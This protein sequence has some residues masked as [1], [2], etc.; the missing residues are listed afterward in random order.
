MSNLG[1]LNETTPS[2]L[3][4]CI[5]LCGSKHNLGVLLYSISY[6]QQ[7]GRAKIRNV[8]GH[9]VA[10]ERSWWA[11]ETG[12]TVRQIDRCLP[13]LAAGGLIEKRPYWF[14]GKLCLFMRL[15]KRT[16]DYLK[17]ATTWQ[18]VSEFHDLGKIGFAHMG[19]A[20][21]T[22]SGSA[23]LP[24]ADN[25]NEVTDI[26]PAKSLISGTSNNIIHKHNSF[27]LNVINHTPAAA[28]PPCGKINSLNSTKESPGKTIHTIKSLEDAWKADDLLPESALGLR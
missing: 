20:E 8:A 7:Y 3:A 26:E 6:W 28:S 2:T 17:A 4:R 1:F 12:M 27:G 10:H 16:N 23:L 22:V 15:T 21:I 25:S 5:T 11:R 18:A 9:W 13:R 19:T 14:G 24:E